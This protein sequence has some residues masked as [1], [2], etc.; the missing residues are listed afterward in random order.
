MGSAVFY[1]VREMGGIY[2]TVCK[3]LEVEGYADEVDPYPNKIDELIFVLFGNGEVDGNNLVNDYTVINRKV[4]ADGTL[5]RLKG[6]YG[7]VLL[8]T[9]MARKDIKW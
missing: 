6:P 4:R 2:S 3:L 8:R 9:M 7:G 5:E 1:E